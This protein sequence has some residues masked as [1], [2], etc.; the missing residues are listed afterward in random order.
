MNLHL[1]APSL[2]RSI[3]GQLCLRWVNFMADVDQKDGITGSIG[4]L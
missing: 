1:C 3:V 4:W 2:Y